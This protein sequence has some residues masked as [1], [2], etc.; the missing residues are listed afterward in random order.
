MRVNPI[1]PTRV[2]VCAAGA[3]LAISLASCSPPGARALLQG[4]QLIQQGQ[5]PAAIARLQ[6]ATELLPDNARAWNFLGLA[7]H[8][9]QQPAAAIE[10]YQRALTLD[11]NLTAAR[12]NLGCLLLEQN[13]PPAAAAELSTFTM[14]E[15]D[16]A[17]GWT[18]LGDAQLHLLQLTEADASF[19]RA[20]KI[21]PA[22]P[23]AWNGMGMARAQRSRFPEAITCFTTALEHRTNYAP[24]LRNLAILY[25]QHYR[26]YPLALRKYQEYAAL[27]PPPS[28]VGSV[29]VLIREL[30]NLLNP[31]PPPTNAA[32]AV[33]VTQTSDPIGATGSARI[34]AARVPPATPPAP[35]TNR[36]SITVASRTTPPTPP[37]PARIRTP[38]PS[39]APARTRQDDVT[40]E[41]TPAPSTPAPSTPAP[42]TPAP[43]P[44]APSTPAP[45]TPAPSTPTI[46][47]APA[48]L[49]VAVQSDT[50]RPGFWERV[51]PGNWRRLRSKPVVPVTPLSANPVR[52]LP[53]MTAAPAAALDSR[54]PTISPLP[55]PQVFQRY[56]YRNPPAP[57]PGD[58]AEAERHMAQGIAA[59]TENRWQ[60]AM[61]AYRQAVEADPTYF[62]ATYNL[63]VGYHAGGDL[64]RALPAYEH[65]L[66]VRPRSFNAR[67]NFALAL[68]EARH[69]FEAADESARAID[70]APS[71]P[72][73]HLLLANL[74]AR[75][76]LDHARA[77]THYRKLLELEPD[78][79]QAPSI[80]AWLAA[81]P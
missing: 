52:P 10:A 47:P 78:H 27:Q 15:P 75:E 30:E 54:G 53:E 60:E 71:D 25:H 55:T 20:V 32:L 80:R 67:Y 56:A 46:E 73:P 17:E 66:S 40:P 59:Q 26:N 57:S 81:H 37:P 49:P 61:D 43:S 69:P 64:P 72:R 44:P 19:Q 36:T 13:N 29:L 1:L 51:N 24:A 31:P 8:G 70:L 34:A 62:D 48:A 6:T 14:L 35:D 7:Y 77:R 18:K 33:A 3:I 45:S 28:D 68:A 42:S 41:P 76:L 9:A 74:C 4:E 22:N 5:F 2:A 79:E 21:Q 11:R 38:E 12:F 39:P 65:A 16:S 23:E 58:R 63:A 50:N